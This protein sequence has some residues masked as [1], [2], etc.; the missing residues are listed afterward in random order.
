M[1]LIRN[2]LAETTG[3]VKAVCPASAPDCAD[4]NPMSTQCYIQDTGAGTALNGWYRHDD[5][6][7][8]SYAID[9]FEFRVGNNCEITRE[10]PPGIPDITDQPITYLWATLEVKVPHAQFLKPARSSG[11]SHFF[12]FWNICGGASPRNISSEEYEIHTAWGSAGQSGFRI[13]VRQWDENPD[14][15]LDPISIYHQEWD[16]YDNVIDPNPG[17]YRL[18]WGVNEWLKLEFG[19]QI[20]YANP[21]RYKV[22]LKYL[23]VRGGA[24][25]GTP[26]RTIEDDF[27]RS[28]MPIRTAHH[29]NWDRDP[30]QPTGQGFSVKNLHI[31]NPQR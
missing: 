25:P 18:N 15:K 20:H 6:H 23:E 31:L 30:G 12:K 7:G 29:G 24:I 5:S 26:G 10:F 28:P 14:P 19:L 3:I 4:Q 11:G 22:W 8:G 27:A 21:E 2:L 16:V 17:E 1:V 9:A 13:K